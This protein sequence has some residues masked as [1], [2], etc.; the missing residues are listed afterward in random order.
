MT[1]WILPE[2]LFIGIILGMLSSYYDRRRA[3]ARI[4]RQTRNVR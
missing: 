2:L 3:N 1:I 4:D